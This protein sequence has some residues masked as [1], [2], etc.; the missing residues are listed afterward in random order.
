MGTKQNMQHVS[1]Y[2]SEID[3]AE[4]CFFALFIIPSGFIRI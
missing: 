2:V 4:R 1:A 3:F